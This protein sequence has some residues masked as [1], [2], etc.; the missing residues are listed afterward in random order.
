ML[1]RHGVDWNVLTTIHAANGN[2]GR[3][4]Y[5]YLR[6]D[7]GATFIQ[8][9]P[10]IER[11]TG[12]TLPIA[13]EG[14]GHGVHGRPLYTQEGNGVTRRS[15]TPAQHGRFMIDIFEDWVRH[16]IGAVYVQM[17]DTALAHWYGEPGGMCVHAETC[18]T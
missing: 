10:I 4:V 2:H 12:Q 11:A 3:D 13:E 18:G 5:T 1:K 9:I 14:W 6:D 17:F 16:H 15:V 7:L 8:F